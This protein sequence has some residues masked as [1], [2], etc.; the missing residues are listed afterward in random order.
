MS[1]KR[2]VGPLALAAVVLLGTAGCSLLKPETPGVERELLCRFRSGSRCLTVGDSFWEEKNP[3]WNTYLLTMADQ[4]SCPREVCFE[5]TGNAERDIFAVDGDGGVVWRRTLGPGR[6]SVLVT[7]TMAEI[8]FPV[9]AGEAFRPVGTGMHPRMETPFT[10][11]RM[12]LIGDSVSA[13]TGYIPWDDYAFYSDENFGAS[14]MWWAVL[15][16]HTGMEICNINA[17]S[18]SGVT[19][20]PEN[21]PASRLTAGNSDRCKDL[22]SRSGEAPD[23]ILILIGGN[24]Y[25]KQIPGDRI[26]REY[27]EMISKVQDAYPDAKIHVC[28]Y[29]QNPTFS[30]ENLAELNGLL[31]DIAERAGVGLIDLEDCGIIRDEP[32]KYYIDER[33]HPNELGEIMMGLCAARQLLESEAAV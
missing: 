23:E 8:V 2:V 17:I 30:P 20:T 4:F 28:T 22:S 11:R 10:G 25:M 26:R 24:D 5:L 13:F 19:V 15:A 7:E 16:E 27:L 33:L 29:Y 12:S 31:R 18:S 6:H 9:Q 14:S 1:W 32:K 21:A 3:A